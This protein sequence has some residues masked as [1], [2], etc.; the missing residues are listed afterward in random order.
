[1]ANPTKNTCFCFKKNIL[2]KDDNAV[3]V[4]S[5]AA[6]QLF[7]IYLLF[8]CFFRFAFPFYLS[9]KFFQVHTRVTVKKFLCP[10]LLRVQFNSQ[11]RPKQQLI[12]FS[13]PFYTGQYFQRH[14]PLANG[15]VT[16]G[17]GIGTLAM[18]PFYH[19]LLSNLGWKILLRILSGFAFLMFV[20]ALLYRPLP[21]K[22]KRAHIG[23]KERAKLFDSSVWKIK[24][25][26]FWVVSMSLLFVGYFV[27]FI[28][29]VRRLCC[30]K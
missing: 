3:Y 25:F 26:V 17:S 29:L 27:P 18:G 11:L 6:L 5:C 16:A 24:P 9:S 13:K 19:F 1:M 8:L 20:S 12:V 7:P 2:V 30:N 14:L 15:I 10:F 21:A 22:Y 4:G 28:H 23:R